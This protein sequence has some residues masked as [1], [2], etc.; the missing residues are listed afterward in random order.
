[1]EAIARISED[2]LLRTSS[3]PSG[4]EQEVRAFSFIEFGQEGKGVMC[5]FKFEPL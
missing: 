1:M 2:R 5:A 4:L 3:V